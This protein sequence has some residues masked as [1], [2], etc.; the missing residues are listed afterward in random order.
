MKKSPR[1][2]EVKKLI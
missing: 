1:K 2:Q